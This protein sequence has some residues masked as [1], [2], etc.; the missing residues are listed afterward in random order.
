MMHRL[1]PR[2]VIFA[3]GVCLL[4]SGG[5]ASS[6]PVHFYVLTPLPDAAPLPSL[7]GNLRN[8]DLGIGPVTLPKYLDRSEIVRRASANKLD[9]AEFDQWAEPLQDSVTRVLAA[10]LSRLLSTDALVIYPW[11]RSTRID[12]QVVVEVTRFEGT[13]DG[14][15]GLTARWMILDGEGQQEYVRRHSD[16]EVTPNRQDYD[17]VAAAMSLAVG[18]LSRDI[19]VALQALG[20]P[21]SSR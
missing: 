19:A 13:V 6:P 10:N 21:V 9:L 11:S 8:L 17:A 7:A 12:Y 3:F 15:S 18:K 14:D 16:I 20:Q 5:C 2:L 1:V 4:V